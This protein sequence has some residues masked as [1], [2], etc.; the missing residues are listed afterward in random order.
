MDSFDFKLQR[1][2]RVVKTVM[3]KLDKKGKGIILMHDI[4]PGTA[5]ALPLLLKELKSKGYRV[6]HVSRARA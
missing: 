4:Q 1:P 3:D 6:V 2:H 5:K